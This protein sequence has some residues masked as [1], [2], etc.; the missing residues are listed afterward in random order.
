MVAG[1]ML[2]FCTKCNRPAEWCGVENIIEPFWKEL[3]KVFIYPFSSPHPLILISI[4]ALLIAFFSGPG[5]FN[6]LFR[7][8]LF[9]VGLKYSFEALKA[10]ASGNLRPPPITTKTISDDI[11]QVIK[12]YVLFFLL[13][14]AA[15]WLRINI[16]PLIGVLFLL[17]ALFFAPAMIILLVT[18][19]SLLHALNPMIFLRMTY[20]I[21]WGYVAMYFFLFLL[22]SAPAIAAQFIFR[23]FPPGLHIF[24][25]A[26]AQI[27]YTVVSYYLMGYVILQ[28]H[29]E[30]G[31]KVDFDDFKEQE[32]KKDDAAPVDPGTQILKEINPLI[33]DGKYEEAIATIKKMTHANPISSV[34]LSNRYYALLKMTKKSQDML[35]YSVNHLT[36]LTEGKHKAAA[37]ETYAECLQQDPEFLPGPDALFKLGEWLNETGKIKEA[38][39]TFNRIIKKH[40]Q[41]PL[42]PKS[43]FRAA[44]IFNDRMMKPE[45]AARILKGLKKKYPDHEIIPQ[46]DNYLARIG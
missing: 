12:Q 20:R 2:H 39:N 29:A 42:I 30:I 41:S 38:V 3:P 43:Y 34:E 35:V 13:F 33:Q 6:M 19:N 45:K 14:M 8:A 4:L 7:G 24:L 25:I 17:G 15:G 27:Y 40:P 46:I 10:A 11:D 1:E 28:Y 26:F 32:T 31:Y 23:I 22:G 36:V 5:L 37:L 21:G 9:L 44:Q 18:T 16:A